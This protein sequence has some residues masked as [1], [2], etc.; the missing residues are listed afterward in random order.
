SRYEAPVVCS[1]YDFSAHR[2]MLDIG[3]NTGQFACTVCEHA[4]DLHAA[5]FDLPGV[6]AIGRRT[7][8]GRPGFD[9][10]E[11]VGGDAFADELPRGCDLVTFKSTLHDWPDDKAAEL[12]EAAW[13]ALEPG[14]TLLVFERSRVDLKDY[15]PV[16]FSLLTLLGWAWTLR[17]PERY[18][19][20][21]RRLGAEDLQLEE[22]H[23]DLPWMVLTATK[24]AG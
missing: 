21:L 4:P 20:V 6:V 1:K 5:V 7:L 24:P 22:F 19:A 8:A 23:L 13:S 15:Q 12:L 10:V 17:G 16:P 11:Y 18:E 14:G 3:G 9:R 2:R